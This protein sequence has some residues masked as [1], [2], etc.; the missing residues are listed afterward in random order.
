MVHWCFGLEAYDFFLGQHLYTH[1][2][3]NE[4]YPKRQG[5]LNE[6]FFSWRK[7]PFLDIRYTQPG[8]FC[9]EIIG[10]LPQFRWPAESSFA[11]CLGSRFF[12]FMDFFGTQTHTIHCIVYFPTFTFTIKINQMQLSMPD[13]E[14]LG[15]ETSNFENSFLKNIRWTMAF[16]ANPSNTYMFVKCMNFVYIKYTL[17]KF[18]SLT[19]NLKTMVSKMNLLFQGAIFRFHVKLWEGYSKLIKIDQRLRTPKH[20]RRAHPRSSPCLHVSGLIETDIQLRKA[21]G[22]SR[23]WWRVP[24]GGI[25][26]GTSRSKV[27]L[28]L[29]YEYLLCINLFILFILDAAIMS[30]ERKTCMSSYYIYMQPDTVV[31]WW[32]IG[33]AKRFW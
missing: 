2:P 28:F 18:Q 20:P 3:Y 21:N 4:N 14:H 33:V 7:Q 12:H 17:P 16:K 27:E 9:W 32:S 31:K 8:L 19:W 26:T 1:E 5:K 30:F 10:G 29:I 15:N 25:S 13:M 23:P 11:K 22:Q 6:S 24:V